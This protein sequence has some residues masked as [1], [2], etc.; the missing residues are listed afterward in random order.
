MIKLRL[1]FK[2]IGQYLGENGDC[3]DSYDKTDHKNFNNSYHNVLFCL[4]AT[5]I[6]PG[7]IT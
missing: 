4:F 2:W 7:D 1:L 6:C 3:L 5:L